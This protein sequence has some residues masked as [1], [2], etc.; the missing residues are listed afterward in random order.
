M[1]DATK[2]VICLYGHLDCDGSP[3]VDEK[4]NDGVYSEY[5]I[6]KAKE[7][8]II[9]LPHTGGTAKIIYNELGV[10]NERFEDTYDKNKIINEVLRLLNKEKGAV[11]L[12]PSKRKTG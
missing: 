3:S 2:H 11:A 4:A 10:I 9:A 6:A 7:K 1:I 12:T 8:N 5:S